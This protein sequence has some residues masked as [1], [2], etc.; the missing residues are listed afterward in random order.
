[1]CA[2]APTS[3]LLPHL[4]TGQMDLANYPRPPRLVTVIVV[5]RK[6]ARRWARVRRSGGW[7]RLR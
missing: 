2:P 6:Y 7:G 1:M 5:P 4:I 3:T